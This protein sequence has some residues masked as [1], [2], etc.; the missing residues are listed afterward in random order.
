MRSCVAS[1]VLSTVAAG[2]GSAC[3]LGSELT[4]RVPEPMPATTH[5]PTAGPPGSL[6]SWVGIIMYLPDSPE[7]RQAVTDR[8]AWRR[9]HCLCACL[10]H[11][12]A[13]LESAGLP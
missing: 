1:P 3:R 12:L 11:G 6:H 4:E 7:Q 8:H 9:M 5:L 13:D 2:T 10:W